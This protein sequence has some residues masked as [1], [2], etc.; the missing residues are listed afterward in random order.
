MDGTEIGVL[1]ETNEVSL[2]GLL[3]GGDGRGLKTQL[4][5]ESGGDLT[6]K[7]LEGHL[8]NVKNIDNLAN[9]QIS[10]LLI[11]TDF[12][13]GHGSFLLVTNINQDESDEAS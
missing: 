2:R 7:A 8:N 9:Q 11:T 10:T 12:T 6:D 4:V 5:F 3:K 1:E 13:K